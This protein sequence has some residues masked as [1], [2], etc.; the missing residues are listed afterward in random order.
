MFV[1]QKFNYANKPGPMECYKLNYKLSPYLTKKE[2]GYCID[3]KSD[4]IKPTVNNPII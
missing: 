4:F 1:N 2:L 3:T